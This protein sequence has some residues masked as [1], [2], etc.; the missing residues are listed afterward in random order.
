[1]CGHEQEVLDLE[2]HA[3]KCITKGSKTVQLAPEQ[4]TGTRHSWVDTGGL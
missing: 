4:C 1:M 3:R 2:I